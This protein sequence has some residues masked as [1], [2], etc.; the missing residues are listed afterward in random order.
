MIVEYIEKLENDN[1]RLAKEAIIQEA[2]DN[3]AFQLF[4][5]FKLAYD[6]LISFGV[7]KVPEIVEFDDDVGTFTWQDFTHLAEQLRTRQLT[8]HAAR[9]ALRAAAETC[10]ALTWNKFYRRILL[11]D[12]RCGTSQTTVNKVLKKIAKTDKSALD[13]IVDVFEVQL[14]SAEELE[15]ITGEQYVEPKLDGIRIL[16]ILDKENNAVTLY[17]RNGKV[18]TNFNYVEESLHK[19]LAEIPM[20]IVLDGEMVSRTFQELMKQVNRKAKV[21]TKD[22]KFAVFDII[23]LK[24]FKNK[25]CKVTFQ[26]R[27]DTLEDM[28][29][30]FQQFC[31]IEV[32]GEETCNVFVVPKLLVDLDTAE[33][34]RNLSEFNLAALE[35]KYE[36]VMI[37]SPNSL[38][39]CKRNKNWLK[40]KPIIEVSLTVT[41][42]EEGTGRNKGRMGNI[43]A[44]GEDLGHKIQVSIGTGF[45]DKQRDE[46][47]AVKDKLPG[48]V[49]EVIADAIT[50]DQ[51]DDEWYS[52]RFPRFKT[53]RGFEVGEKI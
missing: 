8:G 39:E 51:S 4:E 47:W 13:Y 25:I 28:E 43:L 9:D 48:M 2:W 44:E 37:K 24:D 42:V 46:F 19:I 41:G 49:I 20:S 45:S 32:N 35:A 15:N 50:K 1:S 18:N 5:G 11:K 52:L 40:A 14:A 21:N 6:S 29:A 12:L 7:K 22:A 31:R 36:G 3:K 53:F 17:T 27:C 23:P 33:G 26:D 38:Y 10:H 34:R 16:A 30:M